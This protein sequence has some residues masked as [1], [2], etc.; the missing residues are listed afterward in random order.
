MIGVGAGAM[1][2]KEVRPIHIY[3]AS[4]TPLTNCEILFYLESSCLSNTDRI[5]MGSHVRSALIR[6]PHSSGEQAKATSSIW[7]PVPLFTSCRSRPDF[8]QPE[9]RAEAVSVVLTHQPGV[10]ERA[11]LRARIEL[12]RLGVR[13]C[14][15]DF[16][17]DRRSVGWPY[18]REYFLCI[19]VTF[20]HIWTCFYSVKFV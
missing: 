3:H 2:L 8:G 1:Y 9:R 15:L 18:K 11:G 16:H 6:H 17:S 14:I 12:F 5:P 20:V 19:L 10:G 7:S 4:S 13:R